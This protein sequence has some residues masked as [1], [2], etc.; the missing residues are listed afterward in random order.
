MSLGTWIVVWDH[1]GGSFTVRSEDEPRIDA[2]VSAFLDSGGTRDT[3]LDLT[4]T[5][6]FDLRLR[7]SNVASWMRSTPEGRRR[8]LDIERLQREETEAF[9][10]EA[11]LNRWED[12]ESWS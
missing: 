5:E 12:G 2:A 8:Q 11:G 6:G 7:T 10:E 9:E 4:T 3:L 1:M